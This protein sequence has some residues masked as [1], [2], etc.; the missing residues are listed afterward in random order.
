MTCPRKQRSVEGQE[1]RIT[2]LV[3]ELAHHKAYSFYHYQY[4]AAQFPL[5]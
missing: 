3:L 1:N 4:D 2:L 5:D